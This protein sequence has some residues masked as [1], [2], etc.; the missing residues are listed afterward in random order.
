[1]ALWNLMRFYGVNKNKKM[2]N[3]IGRIESNLV[4]LFY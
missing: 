2:S 4:V 3:L 1:M